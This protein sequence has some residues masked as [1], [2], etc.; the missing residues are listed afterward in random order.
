M[1]TGK[2]GAEPL[3]DEAIPSAAVF[4]AEGGMGGTR[5]IPRPLAKARGFGMTHL[6]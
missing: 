2:M 6:M 1:G 3:L 4:E 5:G